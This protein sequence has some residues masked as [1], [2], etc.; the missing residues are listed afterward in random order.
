MSW[1]LRF[2]KY[3]WFEDQSK[4]L[5]GLEFDDL[6]KRAES[7]DTDCLVAVGVVHHSR[8]EYSD[9]M[10][11]L[12]LAADRGNSN[13]MIGIGLLHYKGHGVPEN[14][15]EATRWFRMAAFKGNETA[16]LYL[17]FQL[18]GKHHAEAMRWFRIASVIGLNPAYMIGLKAAI[19]SGRRRDCFTLPTCNFARRPVAR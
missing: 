11:C 18:A 3:K 10:R 16:M 19:E 5:E 7:G 6:V 2:Y 8:Q 17:A 1:H 12:S 13:A 4:A 14:E 15:A 9:A